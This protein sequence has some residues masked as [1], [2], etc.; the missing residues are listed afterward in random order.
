M[1]TINKNHIKLTF[2]VISIIFSVHS[3]DQEYPKSFNLENSDKTPNIILMIGDGMGLSQ[4]SAG[5]YSNKNTSAFEEMEYIGLSK[6][7][8]YNQL[9][10]D[11]AASGTAMAC[12]EKTYNGVV[13]IN[14]KN[15]KRKHFCVEQ[16]DTSHSENCSLLGNTVKRGQL[17]TKPK[18]SSTLNGGCS[19]ASPLKF[20]ASLEYV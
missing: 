1:I 5:M 4:I 7:H 19:E 2:L 6:T 20:N 16:T 3:Q 10:T 13:G 11:S 17:F 8:S 14:P 12:G 15:K 9:V 18:V